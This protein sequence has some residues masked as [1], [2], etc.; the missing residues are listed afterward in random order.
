MKML[1][2]AL[3]LLASEQ[4]YA[5]ANLVQFPNHD[6]A[7]QVL[8][9]ASLVFL[10]LGVLLTAWGLLTEA[11]TGRAREGERGDGAQR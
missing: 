7:A 5:H 3:L 10:F 4:A 1:S 11:R 9:P 8:Y 2:G 6:S